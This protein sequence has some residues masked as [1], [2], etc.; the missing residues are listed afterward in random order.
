[1]VIDVL[2][3]LALF[4]L[5]T[6]GLLLLVII[7]SLT[8]SNIL[9]DLCSNPV[10]D[11]GL[12]VTRDRYYAQHLRKKLSNYPDSMCMFIFLTGLQQNV[13]VSSDRCRNYRL[14]CHLIPEPDTCPEHLHTRPALTSIQSLS[15]TCF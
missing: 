10:Y 1:M 11:L 9:Y 6:S 13:L 14:P 5:S 3:F 4:S 15:P 8:C 12:Y 7:V 2:L